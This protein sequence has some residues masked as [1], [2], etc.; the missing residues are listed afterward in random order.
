MKFGIVSALLVVVGFFLTLAMLFGS[1]WE[2][3]PMDSEQTG[4]RGTAIAEII[5]PRTEA[6]DVA[7][8]QVPPP[9]YEFDPADAEGSPKAGEFYEN[10]QVL[11]DISADQF[12][13]LMAAITEWVSPEEGCGYCHNLENLASDEVYTKHVARRMIQMTQT[14]NID[15]KDH[16]QQT[17]VTCYT[18]HRGQPWPEYVWEQHNDGSPPRGMLGGPADQNHPNPEV[19][20]TSL[21][22]DL[23]STYIRSDGEALR[24][25]ASR[26]DGLNNGL[27]TSIQ[28]TEGV[29]GVMMHM[30][31]ALGVNCTYCHNSRA[32]SVWDQSSPQRALAWYGLQML[33]GINQTYVLPL[34]SVLPPHR[35]GAQGD[36]P[37]VSCMTC[38]QG[39]NKPLL[40]QPMAKDYP[41]LLERTSSAP[42]SAS[43]EAAT[44][45]TEETET[46]Q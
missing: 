22:A 10:V 16:V 21:P 13:Y 27:G 20:L 1:G 15:W 35:L 19:G 14:I 6:R 39:V 25:A 17:G 38:H 12:N 30:S 4:Y 43:N 41:S 40:G 3:P 45:A 5:N 42:S 44:P 34:A 11:T 23:L 2:R 24:V 28:Y 7:E 32:F 9:P 46:T 29:Y 8:N 37:A 33:R 26:P 36:A 31:S 18:C